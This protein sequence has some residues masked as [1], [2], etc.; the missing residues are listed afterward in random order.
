CEK[1][2]SCELQA[3]AYRFGITAPRYPYLWPQRE[4]DASHPDIFIDR[5]RCILCARCVRASRDVDG[6]HVFGFYGRGPGKRVAV[7]AH[8][9]LADT[10]AAVTDKALEVCPV[11]ALVPKHQGF[12]VPIGQRPFDQ[13]PIGS[14]TQPEKAPKTR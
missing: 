13:R 7:N 5:N 9:R 14:D 4:L 3:L 6:K 11:G 1:S 10:D 8:A 12:T 2:G